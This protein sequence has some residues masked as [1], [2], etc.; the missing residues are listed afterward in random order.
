MFAYSSKESFPNPE[1]NFAPL[2]RTYTLKYTSGIKAGG[3]HTL[4]VQVS[5]PVGP[6]THESVSTR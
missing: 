4:S 3:D 1:S 2:R 6:W 5:V